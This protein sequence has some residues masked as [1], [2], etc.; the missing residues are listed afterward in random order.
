MHVY[1][2]YLL[3]GIIILQSS[4]QNASIHPNSHQGQ[5]MSPPNQLFL[6]VPAQAHLSLALPAG[7]SAGCPLAIQCPSD[8]FSIKI[9]LPFPM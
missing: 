9:L 4:A 3:C 5:Q 6:S 1:K 7:I 8:R 2:K